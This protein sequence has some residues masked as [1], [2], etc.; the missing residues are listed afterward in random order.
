MSLMFKDYMEIKCLA[1]EDDVDALL[2]LCSAY[3][4][5]QLYKKACDMYNRILQT[6]EM[7]NTLSQEKIEKIK[8]NI[9]FCISPMFSSSYAKDHFHFRYLHNF[10]LKRFRRKRYVFIREEDALEFNSFLRH[11]K[12]S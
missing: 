9:Q 4:D 2:S 7:V 8:N 5:S 10:L 12:V 1:N 11:S 6:P 3:T